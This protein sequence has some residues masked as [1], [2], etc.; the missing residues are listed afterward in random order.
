MKEK[1]QKKRG[2]SK[3]SAKNPWLL[4]LYVKNYTPRSINAISNIKKI[5]KE[6]VPGKYR[7][8][9]IDIVKNPA[10]A[11]KDQIVATPVLIRQSPSPLVK[12]VGDMIDTDRILAYLN[13]K[14]TGALTEKFRA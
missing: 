5:C 11:K 7:L 1:S 8:K 6:Q 2:F 13:L 3:I 12:I 4:T 14:Q 9:V 10:I